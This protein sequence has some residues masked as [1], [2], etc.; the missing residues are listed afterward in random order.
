MY[1]I[2]PPLLKTPIFR[3]FY[4]LWHSQA[5]LTWAFSSRDHV[6]GQ[7]SKQ[8]LAAVY[9]SVQVC[10]LLKRISWAPSNHLTQ[11]KIPLFVRSGPLSLSILFCLNVVLD[12]TRVSPTLNSPLFL[13]FLK[14]AVFEFLVNCKPYITNDWMIGITI[15]LEKLVAYVA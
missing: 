13:S 8:F 1:L 12:Q 3:P 5:M 14:Q 15:V 7:W 10:F 4:S 6:G 11:S 9:N 2:S